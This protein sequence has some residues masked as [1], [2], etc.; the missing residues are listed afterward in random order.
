MKFR[1]DECGRGF[2]Y[3]T[4]GKFMTFHF[5]ESHIQVKDRSGR[6]TV[7]VWK[8]FSASGAGDFVRIDDKLKAEK[9]LNIL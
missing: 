1:S 9:Y 3:R 7:P 2:G 8:W 4:N 5:D 6:K